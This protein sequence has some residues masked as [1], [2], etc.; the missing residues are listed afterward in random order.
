MGM[1][2][3]QVSLSL[4]QVSKSQSQDVGNRTV[5]FDDQGHPVD[6]TFEHN[7]VTAIH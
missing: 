5:N 7:K 6:V 2:E 3:R 4:G 1:S